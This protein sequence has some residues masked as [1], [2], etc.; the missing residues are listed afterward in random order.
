MQRSDPR[1]LRSTSNPSSALHSVLETAYTIIQKEI[2][3]FLNACLTDPRSLG[4]GASEAAAANS[5]SSHE[6]GLFS[7]GVID[8]SK[9]EGEGYSKIGSL[10]ASRASTLELPA[11]GFVVKV[12]LPMTN[13]VPEA[14]YALS[15]RRSLARWTDEN[16]ELKKQLALVTGE[17]M[18]S[19]SYNTVTEESALDFLDT[20]TK[21]F[22]LPVLQDDAVQGTVRALER[23]DAFD[24]VLDRNLY[25]RSS[26]NE[27]QDVDMCIACQALYHSTAPLFLALHRLP[28]GGEMYLPVVAVLEHVMLTFISRVKQRV[29]QLT[30]NKTALRFLVDTSA[31][32]KEQA[33]GAVMERRRAF[34]QLVQAYADGTMLQTP[35][36]EGVMMNKDPNLVPLS[37]PASDT[38]ARNGT[39]GDE[40]KLSAVVSEFDLAGGVDR[41]E[42]NLKF[43]LA[44]LQSLLEFDKDFK[45][46][47]IIVC[48]DEELMKAATLA[49]SLLKLSSL[50]ESRL[51]VRSSGSFEKP[52]T[53]TRAL[54]EAI[55][56]IK[57]HGI[58]MVKFCRVDMILQT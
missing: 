47:N 17:D 55:K 53:A 22:L 50:F 29:S 1:L 28:A 2:K 7:L 3:G 49:H 33:F 45:M 46:K 54:R 25:A 58:K 10:T 52:L 23:D 42:Q 37:P 8:T 56:T 51:K 34:A 13:T 38:K 15:F 39:A 4:D 36:E 32:G 12:L 18:T 26:S 21:Q 41:E 16:E 14:R 48:K 24:P 40:T 9:R 44:H 5:V 27:P 11:E 30:A 43:E 35:V 20:F 31:G 19:P 6:T 57:A